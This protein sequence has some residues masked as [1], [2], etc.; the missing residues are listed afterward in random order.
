MSRET[1]GVYIWF[2]CFLHSAACT[3]SVTSSETELVLACLNIRAPVSEPNLVKT[4][5]SVFGF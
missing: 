2:N 3:A 5:C 4:P 1:F